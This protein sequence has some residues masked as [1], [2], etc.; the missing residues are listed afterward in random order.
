M[1]L[2][3]VDTK[4]ANLN[5]VYQACLRLDNVNVKISSCIDD[6]K[7]ADKLILPGVG[8]ASYIMSGIYDNRL[9]DFLV[10]NTKDLLG[11]CLGMQVLT[12]YSKEVPLHTKLLK[13]ETLGIIDTKVEKI[14]SHGLTLPHM[15]WNTI[16]HN[17]HPLFKDIPQDSYFYF[18]HSYCVPPCPYAIAACDYGEPFSAAIAKGNFMGVQFHPEKSG[19]LGQKLL[20]NFIKL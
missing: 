12:N 2:V 11:I 13:V 7:N 3:I 4:S 15:G 17:N 18:V 20:E 5:S 1:N 6:L 8:T 16:R 10:Y 19:A 9:K 14:N